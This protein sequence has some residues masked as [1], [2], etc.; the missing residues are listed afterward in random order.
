MKCENVFIYGNWMKYSLT[1]A[2]GTIACW[3]SANTAS[4]QGSHNGGWVIG[5]NGWFAAI[6]RCTQWAK[7]EGLAGNGEK[8]NQ[9]N[10]EEQNWENG[11]NISTLDHFLGEEV[12]FDYGISFPG[13]WPFY[14][15][16]IWL[17]WI[18]FIVGNVELWNRKPI[19]GKQTNFGG[20]NLRW[21]EN[22]MNR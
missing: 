9:G 2:S 15:Q 4:G 7:H 20:S 10:W 14:R 16:I 19:E 12:N 17:W 5:N 8:A 13:N 11:Q 3:A 18:D 22:K 21:K 6:G 1:P